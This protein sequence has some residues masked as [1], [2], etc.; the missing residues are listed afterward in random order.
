MSRKLRLVLVALVCAVAI[1]STACADLT[2]PRG[3]GV[4][5]QGQHSENC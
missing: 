4:L 1:G 2:A 3:D 5:C